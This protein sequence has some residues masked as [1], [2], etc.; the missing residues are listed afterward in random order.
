MRESRGLRNNTPC[1]PM[2]FCRRP[3]TSKPTFR[4]CHKKKSDRCPC[5]ST[6]GLW[7]PGAEPQSVPECK[8]QG[9]RSHH[10]TGHGR[11]HHRRIHHG[12]VHILGTHGDDEKEE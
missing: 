11:V 6:L 5:K 12:G 10:C 9:P 3:H 1:P 7:N 8:M 2:E 4:N